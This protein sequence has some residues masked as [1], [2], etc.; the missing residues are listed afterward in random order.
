M[1]CDG[2]KNV[3]IGRDLELDIAYTHSEFR[4][5]FPKLSWSTQVMICELEIQWKI[6]YECGWFQYSAQV[7]QIIWFSSSVGLAIWWCCD[8]TRFDPHPGHVDPFF[9]LQI[10]K[11]CIGEIE[12][13]NKKNQ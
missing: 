5:Y 6:F 8:M 11:V 3:Q 12:K 10:C 2:A 7:H 13:K 1:K 4:T 9:F